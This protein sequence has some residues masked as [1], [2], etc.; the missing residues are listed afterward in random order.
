MYY[1]IILLGYTDCSIGSYSIY[2]NDVTIT[3]RRFH[4]DFINFRSIISIIMRYFYAML[5]DLKEN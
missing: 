3:T 5:R 1:I 2:H 4:R